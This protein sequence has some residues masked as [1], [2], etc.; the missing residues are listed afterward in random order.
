MENTGNTQVTVTAHGEPNNIEEK[1]ASI[2]RERLSVIQLAE[3]LGNVSEACRR[4]GT[5][6]TTFYQWR[7]R[8]I[9]YGVEGLKDRPPVHKQHPNTTSPSVVEE[10]LL[11]SLKN[12]EWGCVR[13]SE[14]LKRDGISISSPTVQKILS[15]HGI[16]T[17]RERM[18]NKNGKGAG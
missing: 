13:I 14:Q 15:S 5:N 6:R 17:R 1:R 18:A 16:G 3:R 11:L 2:V 9:N 4:S 10:I 12:P 7:K 8:F